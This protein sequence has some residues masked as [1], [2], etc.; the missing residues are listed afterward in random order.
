CSSGET[1]CPRSSDSVG[2]IAQPART[3][4]TPAAR[5]NSFVAF[6]ISSLVGPRNA[7]LWGIS[8]LGG[9]ITPLQRSC[10]NIRLHLRCGLPEGSVGTSDNRQQKARAVEPPRASATC[11]TQLLERGEDCALFAG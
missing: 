4:A 2:L 1:L 7:V 3:S 9:S 10:N 6:M 11:A 8:G 5:P